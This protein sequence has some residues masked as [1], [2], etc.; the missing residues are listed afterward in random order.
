M[1]RALDN[2]LFFNRIIWPDLTLELSHRDGSNGGS[3]RTFV[4]ISKENYPCFEKEKSYLEHRFDNYSE[5][6]FVAPV[7]SYIY[8]YIYTELCSR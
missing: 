2:L 7:Y 1:Y 3:Q 4:C 5:I 6:L 8:I